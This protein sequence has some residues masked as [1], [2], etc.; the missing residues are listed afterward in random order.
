M[1]WVLLETEAEDDLRVLENNYQKISPQV[2][3]RFRKAV[4][5]C[6][7]SLET[8]P[9][10]FP[11]VDEIHGIAVRRILVANFPKALLYMINEAEAEVKV[12]RCYDTRSSDIQPRKT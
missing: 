4:A 5:T 1:F 12:L 11:V 3:L 2:A 10:G 6:F 9:L 7:S 8:F